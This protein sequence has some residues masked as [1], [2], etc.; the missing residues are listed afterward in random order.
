MFPLGKDDTKYVLLTK[1]YVSTAEFEGKKILK[2]DPEG[3]AVLAR[4]AMRNVSFCCA[5]RT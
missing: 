5:R 4:N 1:D 3:L 2:I